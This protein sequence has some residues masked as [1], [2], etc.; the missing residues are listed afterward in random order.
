[1]TKDNKAFLYASRDING[2]VTDLALTDER[3]NIRFSLK[4]STQPSRWLYATYGCSCEDLTESEEYVN[5]DFNGQF[6]AKYIRSATD[7][8]LSSHIYTSGTWR[9]VDRTDGQIVFSGPDAFR[10]HTGS[11]WQLDNTGKTEGIKP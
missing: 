3:G 10:F 4:S 2:K 11:G 6:D 8:L 7:E 1:M 9:N 5:F